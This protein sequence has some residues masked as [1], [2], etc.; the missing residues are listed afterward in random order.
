M[1]GQLRVVQERHEAKIRV[2]LLVTVEA[3]HTGIVA[4]KI[5]FRFLITAEHEDILHD[6]RRG[7]SR[8]VRLSKTVPVQ[9][10]RVNLVGFSLCVRPTTA[11]VQRPRAPA[12]GNQE[13]EREEHCKIRPRIA[14]HI[15]EALPFSK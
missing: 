14:H 3:R 12:R 2:Q 8:Y 10:D 5:H 4:H 13:N 1:D 11:R 15:P 7:L 6:S 9:I